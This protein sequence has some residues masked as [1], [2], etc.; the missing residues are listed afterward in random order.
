MGQK[1]NPHGFRLGITSE[2]TS[3]W[4]ADKQYK[5]YVGEDVKIRKMMSR[6]MERAGIS[7]V[8]IERTQGR[9]RVDIHTARP[10][11]VIGRRGAEADRI[12]GDLEKLTG[13]Q[14]QLNILEVK[15][16]EV[17]AQ[18]VAQGVAEQLS[19]RVS[20]RRAMR[21]AM[22]S[23]MKGG[24]KGIRV[25]CSGRLGGAEMSRSEFYREGRVPLHTLRANIDYGFYEAR[26]TFG[27]IGVKVWIYKGDVVQSRA[28]REAQEAL[29]RQ[30]RR[31]RPRRGP[32]SGSSGTTTG[33][34]DAGRAAARQGERRGRGGAGAGAGGA[35]GAAEATPAPAPAAPASSEAAASTAPAASPADTAGPAAG[36]AT[37]ETE[38]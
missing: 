30:H 6:G 11:I 21:K 35:S 13:K 37:Q 14:V 28:E 25:Q 22:Q 38:G 1:V 27:R 19:S 18:L 23:A 12:R 5:A 29:Q 9:L 33:G 2:F 34:T 32:R 31:E 24:A 4:Y 7:R 16:P 10:G 15:N 20:F 17:D 3:R 26:T 8:D 36:A